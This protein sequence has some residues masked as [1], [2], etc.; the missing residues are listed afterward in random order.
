MNTFI[1]LLSLFL[2][3]LVGAGARKFNLLPE[4]ASKYFNKFIFYISVPAVVFLS[5]ATLDI[6]ELSSFLPFILANI[7][8]VFTGYILAY[9]ILR[10]FNISTN[11]KGVLVY[12][13]NAGNVIYFGFPLLLSIYGT[14][15]F[16]LGVMYATVV[17]TIG[18]LM[19]FYLL[20]INKGGEKL[21]IKDIAR[22]FLGNPVVRA[23]IAGVFVAI[24]NISLPKFLSDSLETLSKTTTGLAL[25]SLGIYLYGKLNFDDFKYALVTSFFKL[26][27]LPLITYIMVYFL[28]KMTGPAAETSVIMASMPTA[29]FS[30]IVAD[31]YGLDKSLTSNAIVL[32]SILFLLTSGLWICILNI[33]G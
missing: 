28:F 17:I 10:Y 25:F 20:G 1:I 2:I 5:I 4:E 6:G 22:D 33:I 21:K 11:K 12:S 24:I 18:D 9:L 3:I 31:A 27:L 15:H 32:S 26:L 13:G 8:V 19:G 23:T 29:V 14:E 7:T 16:N 30:L